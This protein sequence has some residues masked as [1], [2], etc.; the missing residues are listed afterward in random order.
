M[1]ATGRPEREYRSAQHEGSPVKLLAIARFDFGR[2]LRQLSTYVYFVLFAA[3]AALWMAAAGGAFASAR[4]SFG[5]DKVLINGAVRARRSASRSGIRRRDGDR[6]D[7]RARGPAGLR[8]RHRTTSSSPRRSPGATT[9]SGASS[10]RSPRWH[11]C[12]PASRSASSSARTGPASTPRAS[13]RSP[14]L[15]ELHRG[16]TC[17]LLLP[18]MLWLAG[19]FFVLAALTRQMA[20]VYVAGVVVLVGYMV[21]ARPPGRHG[22]QDARRAGRSVGRH[23]VRRARP[24]LE[25]RAEE[26]RSRYRSPACCCGTARSGSASARSSPRSATARSGCRRVAREAGPGGRDAAADRPDPNAAARAA[27]LPAA[28]LDRSAGAYRADAAR[29]HPPVRGRDPARARASSRSCSPA[30]CW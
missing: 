16:P 21:G 25:R 19:C 4:V 7:R 9:S 15:A 13:S 27:P 14:S 28:P 10:A 26:R 30:C 11:W 23:R 17:F 1:S 12:S 29:A 5:G 22:E 18:N 20:P 6:L 2:R 3:L 24:L 8:V